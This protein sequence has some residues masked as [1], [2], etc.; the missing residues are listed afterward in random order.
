MF[1]IKMAG[2]AKNALGTDMMNFLVDKLDEADG[3][4]VLLVGDGDA[5]CAGLDLK[6]VLRQ[7]APGMASFLE[8]LEKLCAKLFDYPGPTVAAVNGH[9]I[10]GGCILALCCD[11]RVGTTN[12]KAKIGL[13]EVAIGLRFPPGILSIV[14]HRVPSRSLRQILLEAALHDPIA[15]VRLGLVDE[16]AEDCVAVGRARLERVAIHPQEAYAQTKADLGRGVTR[17]SDEEQQRFAKEV[18]PV[19]SSDALEQRIAAVLK[20]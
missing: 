18:V 12:P 14:R 5:F 1:E 20:R 16:L 11:H 13:N 7:D 10:A 8:L 17:V 15:A 6:E 2:P 9:A 19:W 4:A 3:R